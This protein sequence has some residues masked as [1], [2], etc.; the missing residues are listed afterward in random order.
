MV[1][2]ASGMAT[3]LESHGVPLDTRYFASMLAFA[4]VPLVLSAVA[5][6]LLVRK[7]WLESSHSSVPSEGVSAR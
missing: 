7:D 2:V 6:Y 4:S 5:D 1:L 3:V